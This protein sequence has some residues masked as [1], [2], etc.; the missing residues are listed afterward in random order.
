M[1][2][3]TAGGYFLCTGYGWGVAHGLSDADLR[4]YFTKKPTEN[5][6]VHFLDPEQMLSY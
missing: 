1:I 5:K 4:F 3:L 2:T 6:S